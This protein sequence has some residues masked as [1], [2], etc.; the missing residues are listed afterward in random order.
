[1]RLT[2]KRHGRDR[3]AVRI[4]DDQML[5]GPAGARHG[6]ARFFQCEEKLVPQERLRGTRQAVPF[7]RIDLRDAV[8]KSRRPAGH[9]WAARGSAWASASIRS[10]YLSASG[11][12]M[13]PVPADVTAWRY[14]G[15]ATSPA[16]K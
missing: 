3:G 16:A 14:T 7:Q 2:E 13:H 15:S 8:E 9:A 4:F 10:R 12:A 6:A 11:A 5:R 1:M